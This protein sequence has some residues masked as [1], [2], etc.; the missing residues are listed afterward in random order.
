MMSRPMRAR[1][2]KPFSIQKW[3]GFRLVAPHAGAWIETS[4]LIY[5]SKPT[6][7]APHAG[8]WIETCPESGGK[9]TIDVAP[10]AGAWIETPLAWAKI[11]PHCCRAPCGRVD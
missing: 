7:V 4:M 2:L 6:S 1:G 11:T 3:G 9:E 5:T 10:H 8:A